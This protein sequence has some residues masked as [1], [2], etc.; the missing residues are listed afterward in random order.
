M[1]QCFLFVLFGCSRAGVKY[2][3]IVSIAVVVVPRP[4]CF[5]TLIW[6]APLASRADTILLM[7]N[8]VSVK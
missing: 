6:C 7:W 5:F 3:I 4:S 1:L 8:E 2:S